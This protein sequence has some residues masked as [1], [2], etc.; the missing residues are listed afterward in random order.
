MKG[1]GFVLRGLITAVSP[2]CSFLPQIHLFWSDQY[3]MQRRTLFQH[4]Q[5][6]KPVMVFCPGKK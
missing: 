6:A 3:R 5:G 1:L 4:F 2:A